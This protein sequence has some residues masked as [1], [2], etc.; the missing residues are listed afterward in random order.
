M[1]IKC[2][3]T[4]GGDAMVNVEA[5]AAVIP[6]SREGAAVIVGLGLR[7]EVEGDVLDVAAL[8]WGRDGWISADE[9][10]APAAGSEAPPA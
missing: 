8:V 10:P 7:E 6:G 1:I 5:V 3:R 9:K 2:K 4:A